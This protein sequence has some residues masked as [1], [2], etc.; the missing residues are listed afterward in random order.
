MSLKTLFKEYKET[1]KVA[2]MNTEGVDFKTKPGREM[3]KAS[4]QEKLKSL[5]SELQKEV[6]QSVFTVMVGGTGAQDLATLAAKNSDAIAVDANEVYQKLAER[7]LETMGS[8]KTFG[9]T[10]FLALRF[11]LT[12]LGTKFQKPFSLGDFKSDM[13]APTSKDVSSVVESMVKSAN[14][15]NL[16][17]AYIEDQTLTKVFENELDS[18]VIPVFVLNVKDED[19]A[20][21][22]GVLFRGKNISVNVSKEEVNQES[23]TSIF[24]QIKKNLKGK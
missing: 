24:E 10:Q 19:Q 3:L 12:L 4:A 7:C 15:L 16:A 22:G 23:V 9:I 1:E 13:Y 20:E 17:K 2:L 14:G 8:S 6:T 11:E 21:L 5:N 18:K